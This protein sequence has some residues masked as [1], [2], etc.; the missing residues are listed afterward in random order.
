MSWAK[1]A[2]PIRVKVP[3]NVRCPNYLPKSVRQRVLEVVSRAG[4][5]YPM[6]SVEF[7]EQKLQFMANF[8][9][10]R[11]TELRRI[12]GK[13][14]KGWNTNGT[15]QIQQIFRLKMVPRVPIRIFPSANSPSKCPRRRLTMLLSICAPFTGTC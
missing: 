13:K 6:I 3:L 15:R 12:R 5:R 7:Y 8:I 4:W 2:V 1:N 9:I 10:D 11:L 14:A